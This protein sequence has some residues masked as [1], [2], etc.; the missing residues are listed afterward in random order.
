MCVCNIY[1]RDKLDP[2]HTYN[3]YTVDIGL[4]RV[5]VMPM[6]SIVSNLLQ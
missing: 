5:L 2:L 1:G 6:Y 4:R 3:T